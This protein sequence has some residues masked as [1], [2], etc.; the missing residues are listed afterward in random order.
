[1]KLRLTSRLTFLCGVTLSTKPVREC[2]AL[3]AHEVDGEDDRSAL[4]FACASE[5]ASWSWPVFSVSHAGALLGSYAA[6]DSAVLHVS[7]VAGGGA[8]SCPLAA[9]L[10]DWVAS[11]AVW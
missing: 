4:F 3:R 11:G 7:R 1:M 6:L 9:N 2:W 10:S 8:S 5:H